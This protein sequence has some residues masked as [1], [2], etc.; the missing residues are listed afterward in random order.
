MGE[1]GTF[2]SRV[3][4]SGKIMIMNVTPDNIKLTVVSGQARWRM[5]QS[6]KARRE[7]TIICL[8]PDNKTGSNNISGSHDIKTFILNGIGVDRIET[9]PESNLD[10]HLD[11]LNA[12]NIHSGPFR[13]TSTDNPTLHLTFT[14]VGNRQTI[15]LLS[16][17]TI[18]KLYICESSG[19]TR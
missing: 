6:W 12:A 2:C 3:Q 5:T 15:H 14:E 13:V 17:N 10:G 16:L 7:E 18:L 1:C 11:E 4:R 9:K 19:L 8:L